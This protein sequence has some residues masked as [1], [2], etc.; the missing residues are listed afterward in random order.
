MQ[1]VALALAVSA[2]VLLGGVLW[3]AVDGLYIGVAAFIIGSGVQVGWL[4]YKVQ[5]TLARLE[6]R[7]GFTRA[8]QV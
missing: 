8:K 7:Q 1:S 2:S 4:W 3:G 5:P 6:T